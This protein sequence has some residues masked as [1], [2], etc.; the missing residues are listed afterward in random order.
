MISEPET[1]APEFEGTSVKRRKIHHKTRDYNLRRQT[2]INYKHTTLD[3]AN[4]S[5]GYE[6][7]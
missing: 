6:G 7:E 4:D 1:I 2:S 5:L 3:I